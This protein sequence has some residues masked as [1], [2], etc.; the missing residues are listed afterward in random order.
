MKSTINNKQTDYGSTGGIPLA[1]VVAAYGQQEDN[2][3]AAPVCR[4]LA[5]AVLF[6]G[7]L[8]VMLWLGSYRAPLGFE[9]M[10]SNAADPDTQQ[11]MQA[12]SDYMSVYPYR[13]L[14]CIVIPCALAA[15][16]LVYGLTVLVYKNFSRPVTYACLVISLATT[17]IVTLA[18]AVSSGSLSAYAMSGLTIALVGYYVSWAWKMVPYAAVNLKVALEGVSLNWGMYLVALCMTMVGLVWLV[19]WGYTAVG[20]AAY[21]HD[22]CMRAHPEYQNNAQVDDS[23]ACG[24]KGSTFVGLVLSLY[25]TNTV[26]MVSV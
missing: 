5:F 11:A 15:F 9:R 24:I 23:E 14:K 20:L 26:I 2:A 6:I 21:Q 25:W 3:S 10:Q 1:K 17:C 18:G 22:E 13:I 16:G 19:F 12:V 8:L 4:D 7:H